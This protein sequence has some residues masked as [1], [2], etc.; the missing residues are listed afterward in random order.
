M[1]TLLSKASFLC[2]FLIY[3]FFKN[4][5][6]FFPLVLKYVCQAGVQREANPVFSTATAL[7]KNLRDE[8][9]MYTGVLIAA[10]LAPGVANPQ[11]QQRGLP[12]PP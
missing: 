7:K 4:H 12:L 5:F 1:G 10:L 8:Q 6:L 3:Y 9:G 2:I 11:L